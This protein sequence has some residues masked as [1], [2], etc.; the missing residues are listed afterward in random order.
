MTMAKTLK[1][2]VEQARRELQA[3]TGRELGTS[4]G[5]AKED[6][7]WKVSVELV[8]KKS[9]PDG[10]DVLATYEVLTDENGS[11]ISFNRAGMRKRIDTAVTAVE[12]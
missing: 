8:E 10:M 9:I 11:L 2:V 1:E 3:M 6:K 4:V 5:A 12:E 7:G